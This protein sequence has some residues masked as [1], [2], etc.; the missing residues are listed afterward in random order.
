MP[1]NFEQTITEDLEITIDGE[2][3]TVTV[4]V[5][6]VVRATPKSGGEEYIRLQKY[7]PGQSWKWD[8]PVTDWNDAVGTDPATESRWVQE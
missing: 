5:G 4:E 2:T 8:A 6:H 1:R 7:D 3:E